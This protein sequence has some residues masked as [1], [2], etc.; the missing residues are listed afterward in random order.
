MDSTAC[1]EQ[2]SRH[3][4]FGALV[5]DADRAKEKSI[6]KR[7][8]SWIKACAMA[9]E[10]VYGPEG[11]CARTRSLLSYALNEPDLRAEDFFQ[12]KTLLKTPKGEPFRLPQANDVDNSAIPVS[13]QSRI[14]G[15]RSSASPTLIIEN[16]FNPTQAAEWLR[17]RSLSPSALVS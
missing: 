10:F 2:V 5:Q 1:R 7:K 3:R 9:Y 16:V 14:H 12:M 15:D 13:N 17:S 8:A 6:M 4:A 11:A